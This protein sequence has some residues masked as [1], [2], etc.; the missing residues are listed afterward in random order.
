MAV[1]FP[2][3]RGRKYDFAS[4]E[5]SL[6]TTGQAAQIFLESTG[7]DWDDTIEETFLY[8]TNPAPLGRTRGQYTP[9]E[10]T[11]TI[12][13]QSEAVLLDQLGDGF[14]ETTFDLVIK[15]SDVGLPLIVDTL[16][17]CRIVGA[18]GSFASGPDPLTVALKLKPMV[19]LRN[20]K[21]PLVNHLR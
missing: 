7:I 17:Q 2:T 9:G 21:T 4:I 3:V 12:S 14:M 16:E 18:P 11:W 19:V 13:K 20:G 10:A 5:V 1:A 8:G 15:Y 6:A